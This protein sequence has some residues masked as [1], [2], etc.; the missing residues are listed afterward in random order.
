MSLADNGAIVSIGVQEFDET[1]LGRGFYVN[2]DLQSCLDAG[3]TT[4][5]STIDWWA[6]Q[7]QAAIDAWKVDAQ[8]LLESLTRLNRY[9]ELSTGG[10]SSVRLWGNGAGFDNVLLKNAYQVLEV[11]EPWKYYNNRCYRTMAGVF[12]LDPDETPERVGTYH[13]ALDDA[14]TQTLRLQAICKKYSITLS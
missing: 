11:D 3:L 6:K 13:N 2:V 5:K 14:I 12:K 1:S 10:L 8:P 4:S 7:E 9:L